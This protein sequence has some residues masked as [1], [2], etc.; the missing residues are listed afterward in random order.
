MAT[1]EKDFARTNYGSL[2]GFFRA[3]ENEGGYKVY[4]SE[5]NYHAIY[6]PADEHAMFRSRAVRNPRLV[7]QKGATGKS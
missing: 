5:S 3:I 2:E 6:E 1:F 7:W 4:E